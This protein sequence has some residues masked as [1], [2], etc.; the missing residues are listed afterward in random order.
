GLVVAYFWLFVPDAVRSTLDMSWRLLRPS[1][2]LRPGIVA[3]D[4][5]LGDPVEILFLINHI[6]LTPG[7]FVVDY[8]LQ[9]GRL[10]VHA[11]DASD[12]VRIRRGIQDLHRRGRRLIG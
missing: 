3:V 2:P 7:Q 8:D 4:V 5:P 10:Y 1:I 11:V 6:T 12:P 9:R